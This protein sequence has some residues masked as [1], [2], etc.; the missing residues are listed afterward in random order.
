MKSTPLLEVCVDSVEGCLAAHA[1]GATRV[2][3]CASLVEGGT[4]PSAGMLAA[5]LAATPLPVMLMIRPRGGDFLYSEHELGA[6]KL[7]VARA[8]T[9]GA[10]GVVLGLLRPDGTVDEERTRML[11]DLARPLE[12]TFHRAFDMTRDPFEALETLVRLGVERVLTS[13]QERTAVEGLPRLVELARAAAGRISVMP[14]GGVNEEDIR[15]VIDAT[16]AREVH[17]SARGRV[18][19]AMQ[20][21]NSRCSMGSNT[22]GSRTGASSAPDPEYAHMVTDAERVRR[23]VAALRASAERAGE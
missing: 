6:M 14:G 7:D 11:I 19:S 17:V 18:A 15:R 8:R 16:A 20:F 22:P 12:V 13:G 1:G 3:L 4:T 23:C 2:E 5:A 21:R 9:S 10:R